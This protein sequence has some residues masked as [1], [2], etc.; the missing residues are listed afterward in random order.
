MKK[1]W[2]CTFAVFILL[3]TSGCSYRNQSSKIE[4]PMQTVQE[5]KEKEV[6]NSFLG[7]NRNG[8]YVATYSVFEGLDT[9]EVTIN[10]TEISEFENGIVF[11]MD[12][13]DIDMSRFPIYL[14]VTESEIYRLWDFSE[15][16]NK[17]KDETKLIQDAIIV[18]QNQNLPDDLGEEEKGV[19]HYIVSEDSR[20]ESHFYQY[21]DFA[22]LVGYWEG[23]YW[24][25]EKGLVQY[26]SG[27]S[28]GDDI[29]ELIIK[30]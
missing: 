15:E 1:I 29:V 19:H 10:F 21:N 23:F 11:A 4:K 8:R 24:E 3:A 12:I 20:C 27:F 16:S 13:E 9:K 5:N 7:T 30:E 26:R 6:C 17:I 22:N 28:A 2:Y 25:K 18:C 14:Y